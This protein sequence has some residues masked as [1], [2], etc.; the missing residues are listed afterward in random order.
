MISSY[1]SHRLAYSKTLI[2]LFYR[3]LEYFFR[4]P[5]LQ[6][7]TYI[8]FFVFALLYIAYQVTLLYSGFYFGDRF[9]LEDSNLA[10]HS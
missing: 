5:I 3:A 1:A 8:A 9:V 10:S 4:L 7:V 2:L 6:Y